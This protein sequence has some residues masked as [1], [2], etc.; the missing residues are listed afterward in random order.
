MQLG[1]GGYMPTRAEI[2]EQQAEECLRTAA[3][4]DDPK[5]RALMLRQ[6]LHLS[7]CRVNA[8]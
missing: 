7:S 1:P 3:K 4:A 6:D 8:V 2:Y 5:Q